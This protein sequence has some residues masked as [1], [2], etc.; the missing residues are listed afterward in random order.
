MPWADVMSTHRILTS[1]KKI[2]GVPP[3]RDVD[4]LSNVSQHAIAAER[5]T[6]T[7]YPSGNRNGCCETCHLVRDRP[8]RE[9]Y[10]RQ[11]GCQTNELRKSLWFSPNAL[12]SSPSTM[13]ERDRTVRIDDEACGLDRWAEPGQSA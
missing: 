7:G 3:Q 4:T 8:S 6:V 12:I 5:A 13:R 1:Q 9:T 11:P 10:V 2:W